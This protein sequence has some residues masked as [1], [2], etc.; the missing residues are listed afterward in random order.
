MR[1]ESKGYFPTKIIK[2]RHLPK[3]SFLSVELPVSHKKNY[4][5]KTLQFNTKRL[6]H[7]N[8]PLSVFFKRFQ[9]E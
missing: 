2:I 7:I 9:I 4:K 5:A 3:S 6:D 8:F 1:L